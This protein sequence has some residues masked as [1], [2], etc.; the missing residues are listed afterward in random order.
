MTDDRRISGEVTTR[1]SDPVAAVAYGM[2]KDLW[3]EEF[4]SAPSASDLKFILLVRICV[5][6]LNG[7]GGS[8]TIRM[9]FEAL[10]I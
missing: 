7:R 9:A 5:S 3:W 1:A 6:A 2:A 8:D 4:N 10:E